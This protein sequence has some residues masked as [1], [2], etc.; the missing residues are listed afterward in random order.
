[1]SDDKSQQDPSMEEILSSIRRIISEDNEP[2]TSESEKQTE[3]G[4]RDADGEVLELT[5]MVRED[6]STIDIS[7]ETVQSDDD[8]TTPDATGA[9]KP[10]E[11]PPVAEG[12]LVG[13]AAADASVKAL[14]E[15]NRAAEA[16][17]PKLVSPTIGDQGRTIEDMVMESLKPMLRDWLDTNLP[18]L[19]EKLVEKEIRRLVRR[20]DP[21]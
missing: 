7:E 18:V 3:G 20:A 4:D 8:K 5:Q 10:K 6:G 11:S 2:V 14:S 17:E 13:G 12:P 19:V 1:M 21:D 15:L 9:D 16:A